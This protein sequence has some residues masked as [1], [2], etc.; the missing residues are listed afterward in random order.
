MRRPISD[1]DAG[2]PAFPVFGVVERGSA[3]GE[4]E[5]KHW[6]AKLKAICARLKAICNA[7]TRGNCQLRLQRLTNS[8]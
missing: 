2:T 6:N 8:L 3:Y 1:N 5:V 7:P 4:E